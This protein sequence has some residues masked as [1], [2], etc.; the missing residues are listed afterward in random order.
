MAGYQGADA[1][2]GQRSAQRNGF[3][4]SALAGGGIPFL[5]A[6]PAHAIHWEGLP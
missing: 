4:A 6:L 3:S 5:A 2:N 1:A